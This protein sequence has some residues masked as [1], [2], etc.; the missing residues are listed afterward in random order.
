MVGAARS[1][2]TNK[3]KFDAIYHDDPFCKYVLAL[4]A[5][6]KTHKKEQLLKRYEP[7]KLDQASTF[8]LLLELDA[9]GWTH[10]VMSKY[11]RK[12]LK[13]AQFMYTS[14]ETAWHSRESDVSVCRFVLL[15][16]LGLG[17]K[18]FTEVPYYQPQDV[19]K[20]LLGMDV[21]ETKQRRQRVKRVDDSALFCGD[22]VPTLFGKGKKQGTIFSRESKANIRSR[23]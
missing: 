16:L 21:Q 10:E 13:K 6:V 3:L 18:D 17:S 8:Q 22:V 20:R 11:R 9:K 15:C 7:D 5:N 23:S 14:A 4:P 2:K 19:Y 1:P 12:K